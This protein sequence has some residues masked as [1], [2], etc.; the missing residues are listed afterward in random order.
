MNNHKPSCGKSFKPTG[1]ETCIKLSLCCCYQCR[2]CR[3]WCAAAARVKV[4]VCRDVWCRTIK[5]SKLMYKLFFG[6][7]EG[8]LD[9]P[10]ESL[11][12]QDSVRIAQ[13]ATSIGT[14]NQRVPQGFV[15]IS[16]WASSRVS[17]NSLPS[18]FCLNVTMGNLYG[19][20]VPA[21]SS[22]FFLDFQDEPPRRSPGT[23]NLS[24]FSPNLAMGNL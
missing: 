14:S 2:H 10:S 12:P 24:R 9:G 21:N 5:P 4:W 11:P 17:Q 15:W 6:R 22:W 20:L 19:S 1:D 18:R 3:R 7:C 23:A 16:Q 13:G 8:Q